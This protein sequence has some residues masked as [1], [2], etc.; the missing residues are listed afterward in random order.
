[1]PRNT[2]P[3]PA[4]WL[5]G[6]SQCSPRG[7]NFSRDPHRAMGIEDR[8]SGIVGRAE[9]TQRKVGSTCFIFHRFIRSVGLIARVET[10]RLLA[11]QAIR[12]CLGG[13]AA[14]PADIRPWNLR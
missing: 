3:F 5:I 11:N 6:Q 13:S 2:S 8:A 4:S 1:M 7:M 12:E 14:R 10:T 9:R